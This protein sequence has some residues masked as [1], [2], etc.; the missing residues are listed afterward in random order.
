VIEL[1]GAGPDLAAA[2]GRMPGVHSVRAQADRLVVR[3]DAAASDS[4]LRAA[5]AGGGPHV[6]TVREEGRA[7]P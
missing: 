1:A 7:R 4:V 3:A 6:L 2:L 5:L